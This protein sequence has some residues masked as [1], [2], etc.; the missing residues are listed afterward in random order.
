MTVDVE[1]EAVS[2]LALNR[3]GGP[4]PYDTGGLTTQLPRLT[5][6]G[7]TVLVL[8]VATWMSVGHLG[9]HDSFGGRVDVAHRG[10]AW[11]ASRSVRRGWCSA[12]G[13]PR[14]VFGSSATEGEA[15]A[16]SRRFSLVE[17]RRVHL[18]LRRPF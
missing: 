1:R 9:G 6:G 7:S 15:C 4:K 16:T 5:R 3:R 2:E 17:K 11:C 14:S 13:M 8:N 10:A 12:F 18:R